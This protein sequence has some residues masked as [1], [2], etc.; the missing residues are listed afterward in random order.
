MAEGFYP[1]V[2]S[3][4]MMLLSVISVVIVMIMTMRVIISGPVTHYQTTAQTRYEKDGEY[5]IL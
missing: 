5:K 1:V 3:L 4:C 2:D